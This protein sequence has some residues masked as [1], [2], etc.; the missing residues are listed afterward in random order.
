[1][2]DEKTRIHLAEDFANAHGYEQVI[3][4][5]FDG[6]RTHLTTWGE[7]VEQSAA[8]AA[9]GNRLKS[10]MNWPEDTIVESEKVLALK[11]QLQDLIE[12]EKQV[13]L[14]KAKLLAQ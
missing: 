4:L 13:A 7:T 10:L 5:G 2:V 1:M 8:A 14:I 3:I 6:T 11:R 12:L 9:G